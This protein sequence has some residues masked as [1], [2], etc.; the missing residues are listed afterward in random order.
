MSKKEQ[1]KRFLYRI[2][3][4]EKHR[5]FSLA[6]IEE[7]KYWDAYQNAY[8]EAIQHTSTNIAPWYIIP[9]VNK[10]QAHLI[11]GKIILENLQEMKPALTSIDKKE[12]E[13]I[14]QAKKKLEQGL[15]K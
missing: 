13:F 12:K 4:K 5:K 10:L 14:E 11:I 8:E 6:D 15:D 7:R 9:A 2:E 3:H 1:C